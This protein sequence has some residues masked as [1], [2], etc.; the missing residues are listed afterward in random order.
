MLTKADIAMLPK[1]P[2]GSET[3]EKFAEYVQMVMNRVNKKEIIKIVFPERYERAVERASGKQSVIDANLTKEVNQIDRSV[4]VQE[5][6]ASANK[7]WWI[8]FLDKKQDLYENLYNISMDT[9]EETRD[10]ISASRTL[11]QFLPEAP[12]EDKL[13]ITHKVQGEDFKSKLLEMKRELHS[14]ANNSAI[15]VDVIDG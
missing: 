15:D 14:A 9:G 5:L 2:V 3:K 8:T 6:Y 4:Y 13:E 7:H 11:L 12:R 1:S 10:R